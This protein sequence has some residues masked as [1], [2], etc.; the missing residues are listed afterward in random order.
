M[1]SA[2]TFGPIGLIGEFDDVAGRNA[3]GRAMKQIAV[4]HGAQFRHAA[5]RHFRASNS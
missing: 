5:A 2:V 1:I 4:D 3:A